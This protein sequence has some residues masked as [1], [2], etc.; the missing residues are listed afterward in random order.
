MIFEKWK[1]EIRGCHHLRDDPT[2]N[3]LKIKPSLDNF[4]LPQSVAA[5]FTVLVRR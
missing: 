1:E 4:E 2:V 5:V 3:N